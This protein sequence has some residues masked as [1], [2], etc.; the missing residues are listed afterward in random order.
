MQRLR[1]TQQ[2]GSWTMDAV[3]DP[4]ATPGG[5]LGSPPAANPQLA[6][7]PSVQFSLTLPG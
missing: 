4:S 6:V 2:G 1:M 3:S 7:P 5:L